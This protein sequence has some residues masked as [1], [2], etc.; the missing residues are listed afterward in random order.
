MFI[1][2]HAGDFFNAYKVLSESNAALIGRLSN[3][4]TK[5]PEIFG[6]LPAMGVEVVCL[7][8]SVELY[9]KSL[10]RLIEGKP[11]RGH[12]ILELY[13]RLP[14]QVQQE[15]YIHPSIANYGWSPSEFERQI[16]AISDGFEKWRYAHE[17]GTV[18]Y[19]SYFALVFIEAMKSAIA[20]ART[21]GAEH[22]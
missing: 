6:T 2:T 5:P 12:N 1:E 9:M 8:F 21:R 19:N 11:P 16:T 14:K 3:S 18:G 22:S 10:L 20:A 7:A 13:R 17:F 4:A 15:I